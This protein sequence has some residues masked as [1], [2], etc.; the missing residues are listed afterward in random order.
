MRKI[1]FSAILTVAFSINQ[2]CLH[3]KQDILLIKSLNSEIQLDGNIGE[4]E[5]DHATTITNFCS[6]WVSTEEDKTIFRCFCS[7]KYFNFCF[8][9]VDNIITVLDYKDEMTV[10]KGDR[11]ELFFSPSSNLSPYYC[12]EINPNGNILDYK[13]QYYREFDFLWNFN[14]PTIVGKINATGYIVEGRIPISDLNVLGIDFK[15]GFYLGVFRADFFGKDE[16][17]VIWYSWIN[18]QTEVPDFHVHSAFGK[19]KLK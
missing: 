2:G 17:S 10:A 14:Q 1:F 18:P 16:D 13:A 6:P 5:W 9:V 8:E 15:K 12:I 4:L 3:Q 11:V 7:V 19:C